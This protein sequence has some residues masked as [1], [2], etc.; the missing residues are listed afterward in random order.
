[1]STE[2]LTYLQKVEA[3]EAIYQEWVVEN[4]GEDVPRSPYAE[5]QR[6]W[7]L[8]GRE[9]YLTAKAEGDAVKKAL[10]EAAKARLP[11]LRHNHHEP[12][13][14]PGCP[15]CDLQAA[16][17]LAEIARDAFLQAARAEAEYQANQNKDSGWSEHEAWRL[18]GL[19]DGYLAAKAEGDAVKQRLLVVLKATMGYLQTLPESHKP[20][21]VWFRHLREAIAL[22]EG[23]ACHA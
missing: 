8:G 4:G 9:G 3:E 13:F 2:K 21:A 10:V 12:E 15:H 1:M 22:A 14:R 23:E 6:A 7:R 19:R 18:G 17:A 16:I 5:W 20:D 11:S